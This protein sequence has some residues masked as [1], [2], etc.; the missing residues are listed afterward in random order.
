MRLENMSKIIS[1]LILCA[2]VLLGFAQGQSQT[3]SS[4]EILEINFLSTIQATGEEYKGRILFKDADGDAVRADLKIIEAEDPQAIKINGQTPKDN[5][6]SLEIISPPEK[7]KE[8]QGIV[9]LKI[10]T[11]MP[12]EVKIQVVLVDKEGN[13]SEPRGFSF[14]AQGILADLVVSLEQVPSQAFIGGTLE[15]QA[16]LTNQ[17]VVDSGSF[18]VG[19]YLSPD[20]EVTTS[21]LLLGTKDILNLAPGGSSLETFRA[22]IPEDLFQRPGFRPGEM[23]AGVIADDTD[24]VR[25]SSEKNNVASAKLRVEERPPVPPPVADFTASPTS[26]VA[27]LTVQFTNLSKG[28]ITSY[29]WDFGDG[30]TSSEREPRHTYQNAGSYTVSLTVR[31][32]GGEDTKKKPDFIR[33]SV[34]RAIFKVAD[35]SVEPRSP[36]VNETVSIIPTI[37]N[38]GNARGTDLINL[39]VDGAFKGSR[40]LTLEPGK[41]G[42]VSFSYTF[43]EAKSYQVEIKT[44]DD[45]RSI[46][47]TVTRPPRPV[48]RFRAE[49]TS[50][51]PPLT[52][53]FTNL[54]EN[55]TSSYWDFGDGE[56]STATN[57]THTYRDV[58]TYTVRLTVRG[59]GGEDTT[60]QA[61]TVRYPT[62]VLYQDDFND[63]NSGWP[64]DD[65]RGYEDG[66]YSIF[67]EKA[68]YWGGS[69]IPGGKFFDAFCVEVEVRRVGRPEGAYGIVFGFKDWD[70]NYS[71]AI[72][73]DGWY[74]VDRMVEGH[75]I[76]RAWTESPAVKKGT[77]TNRLKILVDASH[78]MKFYVNDQLVR[79]MLFELPYEGGEIGIFAW[80]FEDG[81]RANFDY[82]KVLESNRCTQ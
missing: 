24:R 20:V 66:E 72:S 15:A 81:F 29:L 34:A 12:Q 60:S 74:L 19:L 41:K 22:T 73:T 44:S 58:G 39:Y 16:R 65:W 5:L 42:S 75:W 50:G 62:G 6:V 38:T 63:P 59:P 1:I 69:T 49:P 35:I 9:L 14:V 76:L 8:G 77:A 47:I 17:G 53:R 51:P 7:Q 45:S 30:S 31:G 11:T 18:R 46:T 25:E 21:D 10:A 61:I 82:I 71:F 2:V 37:E 13:E 80:S 68:G 43:T 56:S 48:A 3:G 40:T 79:T 55:Y 57:P 70:N 23:Y 52:V 26:G 33:V 78:N 27:P 36:K 67:M 4:P 54:S 32:P 28:E 64:V